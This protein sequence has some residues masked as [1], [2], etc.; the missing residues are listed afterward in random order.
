M[1]KFILGIDPGFAILG[2]GI[3]EVDSKKIISTNWGA[4]TSHSSEK[5]EYRL[6]KIYEG[7]TQII[8]LYKPEEMSLEK[9]FFN[10]NAKTVISV[11]QSQGIVLLLSALYKIPIFEYTP[12]TSTTT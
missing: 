6:L 2:W 12:L 5:I 4:I 11:S 8:S 3:I 10:K 7:L 9:V 1:S